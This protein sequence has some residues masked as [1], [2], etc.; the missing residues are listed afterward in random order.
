MADEETLQ[1]LSSCDWQRIHDELAAA[2]IMFRESQTP[3]RLSCLKLWGEVAVRKQKDEYP[4]G[5]QA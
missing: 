5:E 4:K 3:F 2:Y 1:V